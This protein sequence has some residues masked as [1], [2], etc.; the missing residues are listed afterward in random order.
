MKKLSAVAMGLIGF[1]FL[2]SACNSGDNGPA[3]VSAGDI[4]GRWT[5]TSQDIAG[6]I[7]FVDTLGDTSG[8]DLDTTYAYSTASGYFLD[9]KANMTYTA[10]FPL[11]GQAKRSASQLADDGT[12]SVKG[13]ILTTVNTYGDTTD[14]A[15][16]LAGKS[17]TFTLSIHDVVQSKYGVST[18]DHDA[19]YHA[20]K[21]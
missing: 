16:S 8:V 3:A 21:E 14:V 6:E 9:F 17:A 19:I 15:V 7:V 20:T 1:G 10:N 18:D 5:I 11:F 13:N 4:E 12:W 2:L